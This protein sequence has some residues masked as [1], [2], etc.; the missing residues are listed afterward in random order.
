MTEATEATV[1][2]TWPLIRGPLDGESVFSNAIHDGTAK[3]PIRQKKND[4]Y[5][6][7]FPVLSWVFSD[8][9]QADA[10][11]EYHLS[12]NGKRLVHVCTHPIQPE[13]T[14]NTGEE[15]AKA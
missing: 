7:G 12:P 4:Q 1:C 13:N 14:G 3:I 6:P 11:A 9:I 15:G 2:Q 10:I 5:P 8:D